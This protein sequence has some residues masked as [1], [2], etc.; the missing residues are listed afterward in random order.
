[1][2]DAYD[3]A[4]EKAKKAK[5]KVAH[6]KVAEAKFREWLSNF[7]PRRFAV[8]S[9]YIISQGLS[10]T[11]KLPH[12]DVI[13][14]DQ[15]ESPILWIEGSPDTSDRGRSLA[16]PAEFVRG[17][18]EVKSAFSSSTVKKTIEHLGDLQVLFDGKDK[19]DD[20]YKLYL[21]PQFFCA[22]VFFDL[23][24]SDSRS[25]AALR[26]FAED[27]MTTRREF[28]GGLILRGEGH[29]WPSTARIRVFG[30]D[31]PEKFY[32]RD[33]HT[34]LS[35]D[36]SDTFSELVKGRDNLSFAAKLSWHEIYFPEFAFELVKRLQGTFDGSIPSFYCWGS[37]R[38]EELR[39]KEL[40]QFDEQE[41]E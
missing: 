34:L 26:R 14:Y 13:I 1:M 39:I 6:G 32:N 27:E 15:M 12:Y 11:E 21:P 3:A 22:A 41:D 24:S 8:T 28:I 4:Y 9:G 35:E 40:K 25:K 38:W 33:G 19:P 37:E 23:R 29:K 18:V 31:K 16:I 2:L 10:S 36:G 5:V 17:V 7:L 30:F 20:K